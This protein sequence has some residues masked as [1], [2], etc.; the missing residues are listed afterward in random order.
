LSDFLINSD[1]IKERTFHYFKKDAESVLERIRNIICFFEAKG[2]KRRQIIMKRKILEQKFLKCLFILS[3]VFVLV[4][5]TSQKE[6]DFKFYI[7][8]NLPNTW[9]YFAIT[10]IERFLADNSKSY[11][12]TIRQSLNK[13]LPEL[14]QSYDDILKTW[15]ENQVEGGSETFK[16]LVYLKNELDIKLNEEHEKKLVKFNNFWEMNGPSNEDLG[17][18]K[19]DE[20]LQEKLKDKQY[21]LLIKVLEKENFEN[22]WYRIEKFSKKD[23]Y[24]FINNVAILRIYFDRLPYLE[25]YFYEDP[26]NYNWYSFWLFG[27]L[28][29]EFC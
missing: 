13:N 14:T 15:E 27:P 24:F 8:D 21:S 5:C 9:K 20:E 7:I 26:I 29:K 18:S 6:K 1:E 23:E 28:I 17:I 2:R 22:F 10:G 3:L 19:D 16:K 4:N 12:I 25:V 11:D